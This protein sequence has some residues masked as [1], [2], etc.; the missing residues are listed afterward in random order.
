MVDSDLRNVWTTMPSPW[1]PSAFSEQVSRFAKASFPDVRSVGTTVFYV[2]LAKNEGVHLYLPHLSFFLFD[3][4]LVLSKHFR[5]DSCAQ[6]AKVSKPA[7]FLR[8][9]P[10][11]HPLDEVPFSHVFPNS[12]GSGHT[13]LFLTAE[14]SPVLPHFLEKWRG[15]AHFLVS[16]RGR[17][18]P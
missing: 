1:T 15:W 9:L 2:G 11:L 6:R 3:F 7:H 13:V 17:A 5:Y 16:N 18:I 14:Q 10:H 8:K 4:G 12:D